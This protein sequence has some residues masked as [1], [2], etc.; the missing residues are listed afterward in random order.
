MEFLNCPVC[1]NDFEVTSSQVKRRTCC[2]AK[3]RGIKRSRDFASGLLAY[4][5]HWLGRNRPK[6]EKEKISK[7]LKKAY[8]EGR[9]NVAETNRKIGS[10]NSIKLK[11]AWQRPEVR[12]NMENRPQHYKKG[13]T[14]PKSEINKRIP[15][16]KK[17]WEG[18]E[19]REWRVKQIL[20]AVQMKPNKIEQRVINLIKNNHL[21]ISYCG[22]G[23]KV[24]RGFNPDFIFENEKKVMEIYGDYWHNLKEVLERDKRRLEAYKKEG[25]DC[26]IIWEHELRKNKHGEKLT[27]KEIVNKI[28]GDEFDFR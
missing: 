1:N 8:S 20:S 9:R 26:V 4:K 3:C 7:G 16:L 5:G 23:R 13:R 28:W 21:P 27:E 15:K 17:A 14:P 10:A 22:D 2:S 19:R 25:Y 6:S 24:I 12:K 18:K 11:E